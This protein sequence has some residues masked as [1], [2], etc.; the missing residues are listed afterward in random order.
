M[1]QAIGDYRAMQASGR[2]VYQLMVD[3][4]A[5]ALALLS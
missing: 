3:D 1:A 2:R 4:V 5:D